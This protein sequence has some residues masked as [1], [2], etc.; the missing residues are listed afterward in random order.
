MPLLNQSHKALTF[1]SFYHVAVF[2]IL[3]QLFRSVARKIFRF[4]HHLLF[5]KY[6]N[7]NRFQ[8]YQNHKIVR[9]C[10]QTNDN[11]VIDNAFTKIDRLFEK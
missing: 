8:I 2:S 7:L 4:E 1:L 5:M 10:L 9:P 6:G 11:T 3:T